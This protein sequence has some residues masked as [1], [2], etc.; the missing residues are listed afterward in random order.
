M[1]GTARLGKDGIETGRLM[2]KPP[3]ITGIPGRSVADP[4][5]VGNPTDR[6]G[7]LGTGRDGKPLG[8]PELIAFGVL[9]FGVVGNT[10]RPLEGLMGSPEM[11]LIGKPVPK[12][13]LRAR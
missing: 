10:G 8:I 9:L 6:L 2:G 13:V 5:S 1:L 4:L 12:S 3:G 11:G 7:R